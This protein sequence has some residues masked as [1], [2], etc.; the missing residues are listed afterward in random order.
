[1]RHSFYLPFKGHYDAMFGLIPST[2]KSSGR[3]QADV[4]RLLQS[5]HIAVG[6]EGAHLEYSNSNF[7]LLAGLKTKV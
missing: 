6:A 2:A 4:R 7:N 1:V 5:S 3:K